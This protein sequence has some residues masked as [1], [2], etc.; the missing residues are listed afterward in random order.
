ITS[1][2]EHASVYECFRE[3]E[4]R[5]F[6]VTYLDADESGAVRPEDVASALRDD[7]ILVSVMSVNNETGRIQPIEQIGELLAERPR[8]LFHVD[9]VQ[10][11]GK[12]PLDPSRK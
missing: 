7:T 4:R 3:L 2:I 5:G 12:M 9:A 1:R 6:D 11:A 10:A 8:V